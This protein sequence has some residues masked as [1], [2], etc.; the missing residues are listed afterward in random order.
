MV[1]DRG[2]GAEHIEW[3]DLRDC[4][5]GLRVVRRY[6]LYLVTGYGVVTVVCGA[7]G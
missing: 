2:V 1:R 4:H 5:I 3:W 7:D 6:K